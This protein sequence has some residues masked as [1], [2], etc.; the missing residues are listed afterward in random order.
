MAV[1]LQHADVGGRAVGGPI[2]IKGDLHHKV[3]IPTSLRKIHAAG[4]VAARTVNEHAFAAAIVGVGDDNFAHV[5]R[6]ASLADD[7]AVFH[8]V[9]FFFKNYVAFGAHNGNDFRFAGA[10][11]NSHAAAVES[12]GH[13]FLGF[14]GKNGRIG[15]RAAGGG[16]FQP[17][18]VGGDGEVDLA[19]GGAV[20][21]RE[22]RT[23]GIQG[24][25]RIAVAENGGLFGTGH[26]LNIDE[27]IVGA[28]S[29]FDHTAKIRGKAHSPRLFESGFQHNGAFLSLAVASHR[30]DLVVE[31]VEN[32][33]DLVG[34][35]TVGVEV[36]KGNAARTGSHQTVRC[37]QVQVEEAAHVLIV[38]RDKVGIGT[39]DNFRGDLCDFCESAGRRGIESRSQ[40]H[41]IFGGARIGL[42]QYHGLGINV[43]SIRHDRGVAGVVVED[44]PAFLFGHLG[45][46]F[47]AF[48]IFL[49]NDAGEDR[50]A[51]QKQ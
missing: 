40:D 31:M 32:D 16:D 30:R 12:V 38:K 45:A 9:E 24:N 42:A 7:V 11:G 25:D 21:E 8:I 29:A 51:D 20:E 19:F 5:E 6:P 50:N 22:L 34:S 13:V 43:G 27:I 1:F 36:F 35:Q 48:K 10:A 33:G 49:E 46:H 15:K 28:G 39:G 2:H 17:I 3:F 47:V 37:V 26:V 4:V 14:Q 44:F 41:D 18:G 23:G